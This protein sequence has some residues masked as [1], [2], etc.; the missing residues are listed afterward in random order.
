MTQYDTIA[1][2]ATATHC[3]TLQHTATHYN[4]HTMTHY[5]TIHPNA[6]THSRVRYDL[7][8]REP[9]LI[10]RWDMTHSY[11]QHDLFICVKWLVR[12]TRCIRMLS[13]IIDESISHIWMS[14]VSRMNES[15]LTHE[16]VMAHTWM[17]HISRM[18][19]ACPTRWFCDISTTRWLRIVKILCGF[20]DDSLRVLWWFVASMIFRRLVLFVMSRPLIDF[21]VVRGIWV[22]LRVRESFVISR[23]LVE[24]AVVR[25]FRGIWL[26][27]GHKFVVF[28]W[29]IEFVSR[30]WYAESLSSSR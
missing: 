20:F 13:L 1:P 11:V 14:H 22:T 27:H 30:S 3:N 16:W 29:R 4:T 12:T 17:S 2:R 21:A 5:D 26:T 28:R 9:W 10:H 23:V 25:V 15:W 24:F 7:F 18:N 8:I 6:I 19:A